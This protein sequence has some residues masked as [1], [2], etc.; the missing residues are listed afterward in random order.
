[1][2][3]RNERSDVR[4][5]LN[6]DAMYGRDEVIAQAAPDQELWVPV[7]NPATGRLPNF[8]VIGA[9]KSGS[10]TLFTYLA[11]HPQLFMCTPKEPQFFSRRHV[12]ER[13]FDW[14]R[15]LFA[16]ARPEQLL[17]EASTCYSRWP[18]FGDV[19]RRLHAHVP[20]ARLIYQMRHPVERAYSHYGHLMQIREAAGEP[21]LSFDE[22]LEVYPEI[23]DASLYLIQIERFLPYYPRERFLFMTL[24]AYTDDPARELT[25]V[26]RFLQVD[27][28]DLIGMS[29]PVQANRAGDALQTKLWRRAVDSARAL[30][31][32]NVVVRLI[33]KPLRPKLRNWVLRSG[34]GRRATLRGLQQHRAK[35]SPLTDAAR[36]RLVERF[37]EPTRQL[38]RFLGQ[39]LSGW[40]A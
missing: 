29:G 33:P 30:P 12:W 5:R 25:R 13:G 24:D 32:A 2:G 18:H 16:S 17:G 7:G 37:A 19:P 22:A 9:M 14:Y 35:L 4:E 20:D 28:L 21:I 23:V 40:L 15:G 31:G 27:E 8:I 10:T 36:Q 3:G 39:D 34:L 1:M 38:E 26:Q 6:S 11:R